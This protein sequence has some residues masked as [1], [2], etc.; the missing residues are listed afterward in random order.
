M[1]LAVD[2]DLIS[3][4]IFVSGTLEKIGKTNNLMLEYDKIMKLIEQGGEDD[5]LEHKETDEILNEPHD[6]SEEYS[7]DFKD[8]PYEQPKEK[9]QESVPE[10]PEGQRPTDEAEAEGEGLDQ[11]IDDEEMISIAENCLI[12]IAE[13]LLNKK[14]TI[15]QLFKEDIID[16]E[17]EG[18]KIELLLPLSFLEGLK[19]LE[20]NDF[21][22]IEIA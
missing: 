11:E 3:Y 19:R 20:I 2:D 7:N 13:E 9:P 1:D 6:Y 5:H 12:K 18:E 16:E 10:E 14:L 17:I 22:Q 8:K 15:R 21:S 4:L